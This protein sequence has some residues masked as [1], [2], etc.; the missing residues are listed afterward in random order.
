MFKAGSRF[1]EWPYLGNLL[2]DI[3]WE[4]K[5]KSEEIKECSKEIAGFI[6]KHFPASARILIPPPVESPWGTRNDHHEK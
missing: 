6:W 1:I 4:I 3:T 2:C 5:N